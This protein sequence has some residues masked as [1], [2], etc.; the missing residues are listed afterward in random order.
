VRLLVQLRLLVLVLV[1]LP[2]LVRLPVLVLPDLCV[3]KYHIDDFQTMPEPWLGCNRRGCH[4]R[5][6]GR[7]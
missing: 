3:Q 5:Q 1:L 7:T 4:P 2:V 6:L